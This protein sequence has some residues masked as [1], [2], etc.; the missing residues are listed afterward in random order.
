MSAGLAASTVTPGS[1][2]PDVSFTTPAMDACACAVAGTSSRH[3]KAANRRYPPMCPSLADVL[4]WQPVTVMFSADER[5]KAMHATTSNPRPAT[6]APVW[7][8]RN[9]SG[10]PENW[11]TRRC[12][13]LGARRE[14][15]D[16]I[17]PAKDP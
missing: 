1:T 11:K 9:L 17:Q 14:S 5:W 16:E 4:T 2:A 15:A 6:T 13:D 10:D 12:Q 3:A 7:D 8:G